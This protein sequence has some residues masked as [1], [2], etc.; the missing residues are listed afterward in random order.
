MNLNP[1]AGKRKTQAGNGN[2]A[3]PSK[4]PPT[5]QHIPV[6]AVQDNVAII[7][8]RINKMPV[9]TIAAV[10]QIGAVDI[11]RMSLSERG[12]FI[13]R[14][15][16]TMRGWRFARQ[17]II[18]RQ[19]QD[20][21][22]FLFREREYAAQWQKEGDRNRAELLTALLGFMEQVTMLANPLVAVYYIV[23][24]YMIPTTATQKGS[25]TQG[26]YQEGL[27]ILSDRARMV[28]QSL[29]QLGLGVIRLNDDAIIEMLYAFYHPNMPAL[30]L[31]PREKIASLLV[32]GETP[33]P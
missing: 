23:L 18:G 25:V 14:Y 13:V 15:T 11:T 7:R 17:I 19:R 27:Q 24:P 1:F 22:E 29:T 33:L 12:A 3:S 10:M 26:Q 20:L 6:S 28:H 21:E 31:T 8:M 30:W 4:L 32:T 2:G 5:Q 9:T 16:E